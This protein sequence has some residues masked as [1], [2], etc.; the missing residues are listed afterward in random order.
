M[1]SV[2]IDKKALKELKKL[3]RTAQLEISAS[4][5]GLEKIPGCPASRRCKELSK[6]FVTRMRTDEVY[7]IRVGD[8]RIIYTVF[9]TEILICVVKI[10]MRKDVYRFI[11]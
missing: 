8:Y 4:I 3:P 7:R 2:S 6:Q 9:E 5:D 11:T 10:D 1:Y